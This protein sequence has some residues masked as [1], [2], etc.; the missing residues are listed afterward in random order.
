MKQIKT[1]KVEGV[2][3]VQLFVNGIWKNEV[4]LFSQFSKK[5]A[6]AFLMSI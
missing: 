5:D 2:T 3:V 6:I 1:T 4:E